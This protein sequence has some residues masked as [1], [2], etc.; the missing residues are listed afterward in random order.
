MP[1]ETDAFIKLLLLCHGL[2]CLLFVN[3]HTGSHPHSIKG[4]TETQSGGTTDSKLNSDSSVWCF[5][6]NPKTHDIPLG[7]WV[8]LAS[9]W[10]LMMRLGGQRGP[11]RKIAEGQYPGRVISEFVACV[12]ACPVSLVGVILV[13][14]TWRGSKGG[15]P[16]RAGSFGPRSL[17]PRTGTCLLLLDFRKSW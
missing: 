9:A 8:K 14:Q 16:Y 4:E 2:C 5:G 1:L 13:G 12:W 6:F 10:G 11:R 7:G 15:G 17:R 3:N